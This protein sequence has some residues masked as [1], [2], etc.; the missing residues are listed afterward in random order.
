MRKA[1][2]NQITH[3][4]YDTSENVLSE[5]TESGQNLYDYVYLNNTLV[6]RVDHVSPDDG[7]GDGL[8]YDDEVALY[9]TDPDLADTDDDG[10]N[11]G[12]ELAYWGTKWNQDTDGDGRRHIVDADSDNDGFLDGIEIN[13]GSNPSDA[14][15]TP[16]GTMA[17]V[18]ELLLRA[19]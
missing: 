7:D 12:A 9:R 8:R 13:R 18:Y 1:A 6:A 14:S 15:S 11:D 2:N 3:S 10:I 4:Y 17:P 19:E 16:A 5:M